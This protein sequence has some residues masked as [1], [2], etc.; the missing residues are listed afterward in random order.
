VIAVN[1]LLKRAIEGHGGLPRWEQISRFRVAASITGAIWALKG[2][3]GLPDGVALEGKTRAQRLTVTRS[4]S[5]VSTPPG[6]QADRPS[7]PPAACCSPSAATPRRRS[8]GRPAPRR[9]G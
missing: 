9:G 3:P 2:K 1:D 7:R 5:R 4:R 8:L 6:S